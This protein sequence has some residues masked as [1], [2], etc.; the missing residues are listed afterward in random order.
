MRR[1]T[2]FSLALLV[3]LALLLGGCRARQ[4]A[5]AT[6]EDPWGTI[7]V[8]A[9]EPVRLLVATALN[10]EVVGQAGLEQLRG[11]Q[12]AAADRRI[13]SFAVEIISEDTACDPGRAAGVAVNLTRDRRIAAVIGNTCSASCTASAET[14]DSARF[15]MVSPGCSASS[16]VDPVLHI[17]SFLRTVPDDATEARLVAEYAYGELGLRRMAV[18]HD[19]TAETRGAAGAFEAAFRAQGGSIVASRSI[20]RGATSFRP[21]IREIA[22]GQPEAIY[23][24]L[25]LPDAAQLVLQLD[26]TQL[27]GAPV[28]GGRHYQSEWFIQDAGR[29]SEGVY[30]TGPLVEGPQVE[31]LLAGYERQFGTRSTNVVAVAHGYDATR[32]VLDAIQAVASVNAD[33]ELQIGRR[34]LRD[35]LYATSGSEGVSGVLTCTAWGDCS[36]GR[37]AVLQVQGGEWVPV[38]IP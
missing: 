7:T 36:G 34:A 29:S 4:T 35:A 33:G 16:L 19:G 28:I 38:F 26:A 20:Q 22:A 31:S 23:A 21:V 11:A 14:Y 5:A 2:T 3:A 13:E 25:L 12:L 27:A 8:P 1:S 15:T 32:L 9:G 37:I 10:E 24:P 17:P 6:V 18:L 30:A